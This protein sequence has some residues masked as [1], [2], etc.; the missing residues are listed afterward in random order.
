MSFSPISEIPAIEVPPVQEKGLASWYGSGV[1]NDNG[2]HGSITATGEK[3]KPR[4][5]T[6]ASRTIPLNTVV[7]VEDVATGNRVWVRCND[8]GPYGAILEDGSW[9]VK[10][11]R[12][13]PG[14]W[15]GIMDL[16]KG[17]ALALGLNLD[18]G[19]N[20]ILVRYW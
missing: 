19:L 14:E 5:R 6:C 15:R 9:A 8:R 10:L 16:S 12:G 3:F 13:D 4:L 11:S 2:M 20:K 1:N 17:S 7:M 18:K